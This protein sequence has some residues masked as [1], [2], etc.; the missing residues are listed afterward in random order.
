MRKILFYLTLPFRSKY[1]IMNNSYSREWDEILNKLMDKYKFV[2]ERECVAALGDTEIWVANH[3]YASMA[4]YVMLNP[5]LDSKRPSRYTIY[6][7]YKKLKQ[8]SSF[9]KK[10][11]YKEALENVLK[12]INS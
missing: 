2:H 7:A 10:D 1:W 6:K 5:N 12:S 3:P 9:K 8:E 11:E 4:L